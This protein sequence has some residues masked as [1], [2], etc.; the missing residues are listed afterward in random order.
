M[1]KLL[2]PIADRILWGLSNY[3]MRRRYDIACAAARST[4]KKALPRVAETL[5]KQQNEGGLSHS[6]SEFK[7]LELAEFLWHTQPQTV[8][9]LGGGGTTSVLAE[10]V[11]AFPGKLV[12]SVDENMKY[13]ELTRQ[14][15]TPELRDGVNFVHCL[16]NEVK[17]VRGVNVCHYSDSWKSFFPTRTIDLVYVDGPTTTDSSWKT[18]P[19]A[20]VVLLAD[21]GWRIQNIMFDYRLASVRYTVD[22]GRFSSHSIWLHRNALDMT[23]EPWVVNE[24][25]HH[26]FFLSNAFF[27]NKEV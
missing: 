11:A 17:D 9:E 19:C 20:D 18:F 21:D 27:C 13:L 16:R 3:I 23:V 8:L 10:Y 5:E 25:R 2:A 6:F 15:I 24:V 26:S 4:L 12:I 14:R 7:V 22:S 1:R